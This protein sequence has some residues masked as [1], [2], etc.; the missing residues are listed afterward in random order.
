M[1]RK[2][3]DAIAVSNQGLFLNCEITDERKDKHKEI[4]IQYSFPT[5]VTA[6]AFKELLKL[7]GNGWFSHQKFYILNGAVVRVDK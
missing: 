7:I 6:T 1:I 3:I 2:A 4:Y 5:A